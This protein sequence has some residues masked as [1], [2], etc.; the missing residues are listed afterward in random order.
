MKQEVFCRELQKHTL[1]VPEGFH[2]R[3]EA[4]LEAKVTQEARG[5]GAADTIRRSS[6]LGRRVL[7]IAFVV[8]LLLGTAAFAAAHW[9]VFDSLGWLLGSQPPT[10]DSV[11]QSKLH[12][13][14]VNGVEITIQEA[15][16]DGRT[17]L[18]R[19]SYRLPDATEPLGE[20]GPD[21]ERWLRDEELMLREQYN[22]GWWIDH[23]WVNG[24]C[25]D[26]AANSGATV[27]GSDTPGEIVHTE[28]WRL[29]NID[30]KLSGKVEIALPIGQRQPLSDY[31]FRDHPEM[32]DENGALLKPEQGL[33]TF[34]FDAGDTL[35][36]VVKE[37]PNAPTV[38][39][40]VTA[41][42]SEV[43]YTPLMTY[44]TLAMEP[45][46]ESLADYIEENGE[47]LYGDDGTLI[48]PYNGAD[49]YGAWVA[50]LELV[51]GNGKR[52]F[53]DHSGCK[54]YGEDQAEFVYPYLPEKD[55]PEELWLAC[56][57]SEP[58]DLSDAIRVR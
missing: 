37:T 12:R 17:L 26:M 7:I 11:M 8:V 16:Y 1:D 6:G 15:G 54:S 4:F 31:S 50:S 57:S 27:Y 36:R 22:V 53:P 42:V 40:D 58:A 39:P 25:M 30:V 23:F 18:L 9:G 44:I 49:V 56:V 3:V 33:V 46:A 47:G 10:A 24:Q 28:Y 14:T 20:P 41:Q 38:L 45:N 2:Q 55:M 48:W 35:S 29:D 34:T 13:E 52:L 51:D 5:A 43:I 19:Y 32:Y 21:G